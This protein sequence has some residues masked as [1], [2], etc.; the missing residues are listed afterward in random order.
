[1]FNSNSDP[2]KS[3][4]DKSPAKVKSAVGEGA[5]FEGI[6]RFTGGLHIQGKVKGSIIS[7]DANSLL[8]LSETAHVQGDITTAHLI[9]NGKIDGEIKVK[10]KVEFFEKARMNGDV[11]YKILELPSG[12]E[13]NGKLIRM[14]DKGLYENDSN[15]P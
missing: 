4:Q 10:G 2:Q 12:A 5:L 11:H 6:L 14:Q 9:S 15:T 13:I 3:A 8:I 7:D 1:M